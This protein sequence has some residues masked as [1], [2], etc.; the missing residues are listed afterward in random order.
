MSKQHQKTKNVV[1][2]S[3]L[4]GSGK[5]PSR[6]EILPTA[7][8]VP[9]S[10]E[11]ELKSKSSSK[12]NEPNLGGLTDAQLDKGFN[13]LKLNKPRSLT[14]YS[15]SSF[16]L[17]ISDGAALTKRNDI[18][19]VPERKVLAI[20]SLRFILLVPTALIGTPSLTN[21]NYVYE[22]FN[23]DYIYTQTPVPITNPATPT[24]TFDLFANRSALSDSSSLIAR[25]SDFPGEENYTS[26]GQFQT[27]NQ[28]VLGLGGLSSTLYITENQQLISKVTYN[29]VPIVPYVSGGFNLQ[30][31]YEVVIEIKGHLITNTDYEKLLKAS[32]I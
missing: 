22:Q 18:L 31:L 12:N 27:L 19:R 13:Y 11:R 24:M 20:N 28:N 14:F 29:G 10:K 5:S 1:P 9:Q 25:S 15:N 7:A 3:R 17:G 16:I 23:S 30:N 6:K 26:Y 21:N 4:K 2:T 8:V 32:N